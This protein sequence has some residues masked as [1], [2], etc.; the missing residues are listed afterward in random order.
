M[1]R[2][3]F[4]SDHI[5]IEDKLVVKSYRTVGYNT[6]VYNPVLANGW[7]TE[8]EFR[9]LTAMCVISIATALAECVNPNSIASVG[10]KQL[11]QNY[12]DVFALAEKLGVIEAYETKDSQVE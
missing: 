2:V 4:P 9:T 11:E 5:K 3:K 7:L 6:I 10:D 8:K 1:S 12:L